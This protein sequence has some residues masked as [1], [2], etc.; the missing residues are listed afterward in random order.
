MTLALQKNILDL[1]AR[2]KEQMPTMPPS[3]DDGD[4]VWALSARLDALDAALPDLSKLRADFADDHTTAIVKK[5]SDRV[6]QLFTTLQ[7]KLLD[8]DVRR[9]ADL[10]DTHKRRLLPSDYSATQLPQIGMRI[11]FHNLK[12]TDLNGKFATVLPVGDERAGVL[13]DDSG[14]EDVHPLRQPARGGD[15][16]APEWPCLDDLPFQVLP[17]WEWGYLLRAAAFGCSP[18]RLPAWLLV[19]SGPPD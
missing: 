18:G 10:P 11:L 14:H 17:C 4:I 8:S 9:P 1:D 15:W 13:L 7:K 12:R 6:E 16:P 3:V 2:L 19:R 5:T